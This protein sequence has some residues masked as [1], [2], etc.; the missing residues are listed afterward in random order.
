MVFQLFSTTTVR[1]PFLFHVWYS[2]TCVANRVQVKGF[3]VMDPLTWLQPPRTVWMMFIDWAM[4]VKRLLG[5]P[6]LRHLCQGHGVCIPKLR[7]NKIFVC[8][9]WFDSSCIYWDNWIVVCNILR[10]PAV[11]ARRSSSLQTK[12][13]DRGGV[14]E[15]GILH[16]FLPLGPWQFLHPC[17]LSF[18]NSR[19]CCIVD[20]W[21]HLEGCCLNIQFNSEVV[22]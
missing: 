8:C 2:T 16:H 4:L 17:W 13:D 14:G 6:R 12:W 20:L 10:K 15:G 11:R 5:G 18:L 22:P 1:R 21:V 9:V 3:A 19:V 7:T